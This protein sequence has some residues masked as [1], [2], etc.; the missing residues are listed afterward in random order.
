MCSL[1]E[2]PSDIQQHL[3]TFG[4]VTAAGGGQVAPDIQLERQECYWTP[5]VQGTVSPYPKQSAILCDG[6]SAAAGAEPV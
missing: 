3:D 6:N 2:S 1:K 4:V 5:R